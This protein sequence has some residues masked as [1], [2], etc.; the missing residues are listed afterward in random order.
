VT[1]SDLL[2]DYLAQGMKVRGVLASI[3]PSL[4]YP[5]G[6]DVEIRVVDRQATIKVLKRLREQWDT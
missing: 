5:R 3:D 6:K 4:Y 2:R 1:H